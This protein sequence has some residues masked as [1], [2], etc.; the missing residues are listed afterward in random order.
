MEGK[1]T[2]LRIKTS[3]GS[4]NTIAQHLQPD[5]QILGFS[6][7]TIHILSVKTVGLFQNFNK[8]FLL[9]NGN[10]NQTASFA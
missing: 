5:F 2:L 3:Y 6:P 4:S 9:G 10:F 7:A 1:Q 8:I